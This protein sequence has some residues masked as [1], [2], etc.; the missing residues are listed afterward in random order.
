MTAIVFNPTAQG[1]HARGFL[2]ALT[3]R[4]AEARLLPTR[5]AGHAT[6]LATM[7]VNEGATTVVAAGGDGTVNEVLN[8]IALAPDGP[9][10]ARLAVI[11]FGTV[12]VFAKELG[13]P[14]DLDGAWETAVG[15]EERRIDLACLEWDDGSRRRFVQMAGA[16]LD[17]LSIS[18]V[19]WGLK[20]RFGPLAYLWS[21]IEVM[22]LPRPRVLIEADGEHLEGVLAAVGNGRYLGGRYPVFPRASLEDGLLDLVVFPKVGWLTLARVFPRLWND[23]FADSTDAIHRQVA[24]LRLTSPDPLPVHVEGDNVGHLPVTVRIEGARLRVAVPAKNSAIP[25][26]RG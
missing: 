20:K 3:R 7:A 24:T 21:C 11:P 22:F 15:P 17:S 25:G 12:N 23:T 6:E 13:I 8:G 4:G 2:D 16:G 14:E 9:N 1:D 26:R 5:H 10:R 19:R 18:R